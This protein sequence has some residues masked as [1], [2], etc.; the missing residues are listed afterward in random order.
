LRR[1]N[2][3]L[4]CSFDIHSR[5]LLIHP[6]NRLLCQLEVLWNSA[7]RQCFLN[8]VAVLSFYRPSFATFP[9]D[10]SSLDS[11]PESP[12]GSGRCQ[13]RYSLVPRTTFPTL[14]TALAGHHGSRLQWHAE[15]GVL[16]NR[17]RHLAS[18]SGPGEGALSPDRN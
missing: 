7:D 10:P 18:N 11:C 16:D 1:F 5:V 6:S 15:P 13:P 12:S 8:H 9:H 14:A 4:Q 3:P 17:R 2:K